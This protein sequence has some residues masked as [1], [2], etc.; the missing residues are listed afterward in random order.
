MYKKCLSIMLLLH[1]VAFS[2]AQN[3][4]SIKTVNINEVFVWGNEQQRT[5]R[6]KTISVETID[7][8]VYSKLFNGNLM[9]SIEQIAGIQSLSVGSGFSKPMI[10]GMAFNRVSVTE[11]GVKQEGQQWGADHGLEIDA[12]NIERVNIHKG[13]SSLLYGSDAM[14]GVIE[15]LP[16]NIVGK[17]KFF[18]SVNM[19]GRTANGL[20]GGSIMLGSKYKKW[21]IKARYSEQHFADFKVPTDTPADVLETL[22]T[23]FNNVMKTDAILELAKPQEAEIFALTGKAAKDMAIASEKALCWVLYDLGQTTYSPEDRGIARP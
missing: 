1:Y 11:N 10:R 12:F 5:K 18:G 4:D 9:N 14:G 8:E 3:V 17:D 7:E 21:F 2:V 19:L 13:P 23:A 16:P 22:T 20:L 15:I 6:S